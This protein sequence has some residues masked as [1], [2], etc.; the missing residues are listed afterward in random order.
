MIVQYNPLTATDLN[1]AVSYYNRQC[2]ALGDELR[3][4]VYATIDRVRSSPLQFRLLSTPSA[5][6]RHT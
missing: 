3:S 2:P 4:E 6:R 1:S 5:D